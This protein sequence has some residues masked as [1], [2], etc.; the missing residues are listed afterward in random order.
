MI[1]KIISAFL[2]SLALVV[3]VNAAP[4]RVTECH[5]TPNPVTVDQAATL[6][7]TGL[8][9]TYPFTITFDPYPR[10]TSWWTVDGTFT[11]SG[12]YGSRTAYVWVRGHGPS[13]IK[14]GKQLNDYHVIAMCTL[15]VK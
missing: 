6:Y 3:P 2:V 10:G 4:S 12:W 9:T 5:W 11:S 7:V 14:A 13:L 15:E 1:K 8:P